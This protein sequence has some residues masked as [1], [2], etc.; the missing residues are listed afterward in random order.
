MLDS[1]NILPFSTTILYHYYVE[2]VVRPMLSPILQ[3]RGDHLHARY[4]GVE[5]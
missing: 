2:K 3:V 4:E 1:M 5:G